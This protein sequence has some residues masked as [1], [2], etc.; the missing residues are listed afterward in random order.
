MDNKIKLTILDSHALNPGD[1]S[2]DDFNDY[3]DVSVYERTSPEELVNRAKDS[4]AIFINK[5]VISEETIEQ[6][7]KLKYIGVCATGYNVVDIEACRK[8]N[9]IV[10]N[11]PAYSTDAVA[12]H[13]FALITHFTNSVALHSESVHNGDWVRAKDFAYWKNPLMELSGKTLGI[14]G[15]GSIG[16]K[17]AEIG[18]AFGMKVICCTRT[19]KPDMPESVTREELFRRSDFISLHAPLTPET[20]EM[21]NKDSISLMKKTAYL[22]NTARGGFV[23]EKEMAEALKE[24]KIAGYAADVISTEPM[25]EGNPLMDCPNCVITPHIAWAP[26]ETR[27][28]LMNVCLENLKAWL[29]GNPQNVVN[30]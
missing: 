3:A 5:V 8:R 19:Q 2:W 24:G 13:V 11:V 23:N 20:K 26:H 12:Q 1:L 25:I 28:R 27:Q 9:I 18:K 14:F 21:I 6:L 30:K 16:K 17:T 22:I 29:E 4:D 15:Y 7:P 10:T